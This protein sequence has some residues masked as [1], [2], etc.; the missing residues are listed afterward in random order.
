[1]RARAKTL[2]APDISLHFG[3]ITSKRSNN[4]PRSQPKHGLLL[5]RDTFTCFL[6]LNGMFF[7]LLDCL[8]LLPLPHSRFILRNLVPIQPKTD[9]TE[10]M[11]S[12]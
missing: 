4:L 5:L 9:Q 12:H 8:L 1:M 11:Y 7:G 10:Y 3:D 2:R 6:A